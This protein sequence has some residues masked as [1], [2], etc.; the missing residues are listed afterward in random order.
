MKKKIWVVVTLL[1]SA[2]ICFAQENTDYVRKIERYSLSIDTISKENYINNKPSKKVLTIHQ[3]GQIS[4]KKRRLRGGFSEYIT[5][6][7]NSDTIFKIRIHDNLQK[8]LYKQYYYKGNEL[9]MA[10]VELQD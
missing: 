4:D 9:V 5:Y 10:K 6:E 2:T 8:N 3:E 1:I 7:N